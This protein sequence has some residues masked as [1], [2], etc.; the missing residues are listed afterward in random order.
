MSFFLEKELDYS[1]LAQMVDTFVSGELKLLS[2]SIPKT[3][4]EA[5]F[6]LQNN[7]LPLFETL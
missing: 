1:F 6:A 5:H 3:N 2:R 7:K 4:E